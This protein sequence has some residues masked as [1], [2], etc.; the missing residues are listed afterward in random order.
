MPI[1]IFLW[2]Y[3]CLLFLLHF[4]NSGSSW[5]LPEPLS[6]FSWVTSRSFLLGS[7]SFHPILHF[8]LL[9]LT[10]CW[11]AVPLLGLPG[12]VSLPPCVPPGRFLGGPELPYGSAYPG[13]GKPTSASTSRSPPGSAPSDNTCE[14]E[15]LVR[16]ID[17][18]L[19]FLRVIWIQ[20]EILRH[21]YPLSPYCLYGTPAFYIKLRALEGGKFFF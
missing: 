4:S 21:N 8:S 19:V 1:I 14:Q 3:D 18:C 16:W 20:L 17:L 10:R 13:T 11:L 12:G 9:S 7:P 2:R 15:G 5:A 6:P